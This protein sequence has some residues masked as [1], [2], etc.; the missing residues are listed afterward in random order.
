MVL[1]LAEASSGRKAPRL[2]V[3]SWSIINLAATRR[4]CASGVPRSLMAPRPNAWIRPTWTPFSTRKRLTE[5]TRRW[6]NV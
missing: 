5:S 4:F 6:L 3:P 1:A 2:T